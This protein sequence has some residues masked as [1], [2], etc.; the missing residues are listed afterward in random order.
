MIQLAREEGKKLIENDL[1][2]VQKE[3]SGEILAQ[4]KTKNTIK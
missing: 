1:S 3:I 2:K 4:K